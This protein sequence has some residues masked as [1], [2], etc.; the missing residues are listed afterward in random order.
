[1]ISCWREPSVFGDG[2]A[3]CS[4]SRVVI[5]GLARHCPEVLS[6]SQIKLPPRLFFQLQFSLG[7]FFGRKFVWHKLCWQFVLG[8]VGRGILESH[9]AQLLLLSAI[10]MAS[11]NALPAQTAL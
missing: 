4:S 9:L 10:F 2:D 6:I 7:Y 11:I 5:Q 3:G 8:W 1:M